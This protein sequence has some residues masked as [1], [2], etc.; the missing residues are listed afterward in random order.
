LPT[1]L[2]GIVLTI[3]AAILVAYGVQNGDWGNFVQQWQTSRFIH[4][5]SLDFCLLSLLFP[6]LLADDM[7][8]RSWKNPQIFWLISFIP[9]FGPLF[10]LCIRPPLPEVDTIS[11]K[12][13][14]A[15]N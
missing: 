15:A 7:A 8:R 14:P 11:S 4:V 1:Y 3:A 10:Y 13:Q 9:L 5:M 2:T 12:Q 6:A